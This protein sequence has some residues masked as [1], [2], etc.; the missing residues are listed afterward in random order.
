[1]LVDLLFEITQKEA[2]YL[3]GGLKE[4]RRAGAGKPADFD[5]LAGC[6]VLAD[7]KTG[8]VRYCIAKDVDDEMRYQRQQRFAA[9]SGSLPMTYTR[10]LHTRSKDALFACLHRPWEMEVI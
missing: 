10:G 1:L 3:K 4:A 7:M 9:G 2:G 8:Q 6:T 5:F